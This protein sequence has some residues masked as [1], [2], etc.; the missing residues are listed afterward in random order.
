MGI[1]TRGVRAP[2]GYLG[3]GITKLMYRIMGWG[4]LD[5]YLKLLQLSCPCGFQ[6]GIITH[7]PTALLG[8]ILLPT[9]ELT[10]IPWEG[11]LPSV[12][13]VPSSV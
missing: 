5:G 1:Y 8:S 6:S 7:L 11:F 10:S 13:V 2:V 9:A 4:G 3:D 12:V